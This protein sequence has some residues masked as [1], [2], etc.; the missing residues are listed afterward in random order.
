[1][2]HN[3]YDTDGEYNTKPNREMILKKNRKEIRTS[4]AATTTMIPTITITTV[5]NDE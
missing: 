1:M 4:S 3:A 2:L 5:D